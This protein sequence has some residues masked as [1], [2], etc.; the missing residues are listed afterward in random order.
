MTLAL[1]TEYSDLLQKNYKNKYMKKKECTLGIDTSNYT[2]SAALFCHEDNMMYQNRRL[3]PVEEGKCGLRQSDAVFHH[4]QQLH[5]IIDELYRRLDFIPVIKAIGVSA[6]PRDRI[7]SYMPCFTVGVNIANTL[8]TVL[9]IPVFEFSHQMGHIAAAV[10][11]ADAGYLYKDKFLAFHVSGG[12]TEAVIVSPENDNLVVSDIVGKTLDLHAGQAI[13]RIGVKM[14]LPFP[15]GK[16]LEKLALQCEKKVSV[17]PCIKGT[18]CCLSGL[19][20]ICEKLLAENTDRS[21]TALTC[22]MYIEKTIEKMCVA[23]LDKY[24]AMPVLFAGGVMSDSI[25]REELSKKLDCI[26]ASAEL[27]SDNAC[28]TAVLAYD[29]F[30]GI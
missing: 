20:N 25:I 24:G 4:T 28:G 12:T 10:Y 9:N 15:C 16:E 21:E 29:A 5:I 13:D 2:T 7:D 8:G 19:Q 27:S 17:R 1:S 26:F 11:S 23:I 14:G 22:L 6:R 3:L 18:D 30:G